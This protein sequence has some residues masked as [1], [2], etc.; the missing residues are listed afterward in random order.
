MEQAKHDTGERAHDRGRP[1]D[2]APRWW[3][4]DQHYRWQ[5]DQHY[6]CT[7]AFMDG[8]QGAAQGGAL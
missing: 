8:S 3:Q 7:N 1:A 6:R 5:G 2:Q 4:G